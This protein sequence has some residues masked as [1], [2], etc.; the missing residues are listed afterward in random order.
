MTTRLILTLTLI[1][2]TQLVF[3]QVY[4]YFRI[5]DKVDLNNKSATEIYEELVIGNKTIRYFKTLNQSNQ[6]LS[7]ERRDENDNFIAKYTYTYDPVTSVRTSSKKEFKN[8]KGER[9]I[10]TE[11]YEYDKN[12]HLIGVIHLDNSDK[13]FQIVKI[14]NNKYGHPIKLE[15]FTQDG[16]QTGYE[17]VSYDYEENN[18]EYEQVD[19]NGNTYNSGSFTIDHRTKKNNPKSNIEYDKYGNLIKFPNGY[20]EIEYDKFGNWTSI[21]SNRKSDNTFILSQTHR[22]TIK[23]RE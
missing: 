10:N 18:A 19:G 23:Y 14:T 8:D 11:K 9:Y 22:R 21:K 7:D 12:R 1:L 4:L 13:L 20:N 15:T 17:N 5:S 3:G 6:L 2:L 16:H